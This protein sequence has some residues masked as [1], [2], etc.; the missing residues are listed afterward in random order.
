MNFY[1]SVTGWGALFCLVPRL[2]FNPS[3]HSVKNCY[4]MFYRWCCCTVLDSEIP[5]FGAS[6]ATF[7]VFGPRLEIKSS[8]LL[9]LCRV[10]N[11]TDKKYSVT[12]LKALKHIA[13][14]KP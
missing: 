1:G 2:G 6:Q 4:R 9:W 12:G 7:D 5:S 11:A 13:G 8:T 10:G 14:A 3:A